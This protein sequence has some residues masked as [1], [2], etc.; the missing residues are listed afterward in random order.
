VRVW[1]ADTS[2]TFLRGTLTGHTGTVNSVAFSPDGKRIVSGGWDKTVRVWDADTGKPV[3]QPLTGHT[4]RVF[5]VAFSPDGKR[6]VSGSDDKTLRLWNADTGQPIGQPMT[7][8]RPGA[9]LPVDVFGGRNAGPADPDAVASVAFSPDGHRIVSGSYDNTVRVWDADTGKPVGQPL[10]G[11]IMAVLSVA[12]SPDGKL[13]ASGSMDNSVRLWDAVTG[14]PVG[15]PLPGHTAFVFS[16]VFSPDGTTIVSGGGDNTLRV[17]P[18]YPDPASAMC[19]KL[20]TNMSHKQW[21]DWVSPDIDYIK[22]CPDLP[23]AP[24]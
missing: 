6:I 20:T 15:Q 16:V 24:D 7:A 1:N 9:A 10:T 12:F 3:G 19:A 11:H 4:G 13:I 17:W 5:S 2:R 18:T 22:T 8:Q 23:V 14:R 21:R